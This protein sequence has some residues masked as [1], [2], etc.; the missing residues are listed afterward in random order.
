M[1]KQISRAV[2]ASLRMI[3]GHFGGGFPSQ[4]RAPHHRNV[5]PGSCKVERSGGHQFRDQ[6]STRCASGNRRKYAQ[7]I[8]DG[9]PYA[10]K[11]D[12]VRKK[13]IPQATYNKIADHDHR[14]AAEIKVRP[15]GGAT[16]SSAA[17]MFPRNLSRDPLVGS[18]L[19]RRGTGS[20][21]RAGSLRLAQRFGRSAKGDICT[22]RPSFPREVAHSR[23]AS[24]PAPGRCSSQ[25][26]SGLRQI[27]LVGYRRPT[28]RTLGRRYPAPP[29]AESVLPIQAVLPFI[30]AR[31]ACEQYHILSPDS[32]FAAVIRFV[33]SRFLGA[34]FMNA[35]HGVE[36]SAWLS[37]PCDLIERTV[38]YRA[39]LYHGAA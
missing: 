13:I 29:L 31:F 2:I 37:H 34:R 33:A 4:G 39:N 19:L 11:T 14:E 26:G 17:G 27:R 38:P 5:G 36:R 18:I 15:G 24:P 3:L 21:S 22:S 10:K 32:H 16:T 6:G 30:L 8:I 1:K 12:L 20:T 9:R 35:C 7:K 23:A 25:R 28:S